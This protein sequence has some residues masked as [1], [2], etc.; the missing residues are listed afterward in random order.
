MKCALVL[1]AL[2]LA[3]AVAVPVPDRNA[4][5]LKFDSSINGVDGY[6]YQY[7]TSNGISAQ[8]AGE[9]KNFGEASALA[10]RGSFTYTA[11]DGQVYTV[12]YIADENGFQPEGKHIPKE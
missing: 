6:S 2:C 8:E 4:Q 3:M 1:V 9:L 5:T 11:A 7:E 12:N 10:V